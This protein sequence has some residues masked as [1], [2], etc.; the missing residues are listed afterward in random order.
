[1]ADKLLDTG[2]CG[3]PILLMLTVVR[4]WILLSALLVSTGWILSALH[5]LNR[6]GYAVILTSAGIVFIYWQRKTNWRPRKNPAQL[7]HQFRRRF[8]RPAPLLFL[9]LALLALLSGSLYEALNNDADAY[10]LPRVFHWLWSGQWHWIHTFDPRMNIAGCGFEWLSAPLIL[11]TCTDRFLFLINWVSYLMLPGLIF[12]VFK[13]LQVRPRVAW[14][15]MWLLASG[16]C[17]VLQAGSN[18][19]DSFATIYI[20]AAVDLALRAREKNSM[21]DLWLSLLAVALATG[22]KQ[23]NIPLA[24]LWVIAAWPGKRLFWTRRIITTIVVAAFGLLVSIVPVSIFN[25]AHYGT[26]LPVDLARM[27]GGAGFNLNPFWGIIGNSL[28]I[29]VQNLLPPFFPW[30]DSW[31][32]MM[33]RFIHTSFGAH[34]AS[35]EIFGSLRPGIGEVN[36]GIGLGICV[37]TLVSL[38]N[39]NRRPR[40]ANVNGGVANDG[41]VRL[42]RW[43]PFVLLLVFMA[44]DGAFENARQLAPYYPF[45]FPLLLVGAGQARLVRR[46]WWQRLGLLIMGATATLVVIQPNHPLLPAQTLITRLQ[47]EYPHSKLLSM[48]SRIYS[49]QRSLEDQK[50][51]LG[52]ALPPDETIGYVAGINGRYES[53]M[54][55]PFGQRR[56]E[57][58]LP[59]DTPEQL[60]FKGIHYVVIEDIVLQTAN[61]TIEQWLNEYDGNLENK[62]VPDKDPGH[63]VRTLYLVRLRP[64]PGEN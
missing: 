38:L 13:R 56:V 52:D 62:I 21:T 61:E 3:N 9:L 5:Q 17:F 1:V 57:R 14:W 22:A 28:C 16:W 36:A 42:L 48:V 44:R 2:R 49:Y 47:R 64:E 37:L 10:R 46:L 27:P 59:N 15:W 24:L 30:T 40:L 6:T 20:L 11:F 60:R 31:N 51:R 55:L 63:P 50:R 54:W 12:S 19:N 23:T 4:A 53:W 18:F 29:P 34:F 33:D 8:K 41:T 39:G 58:V 45:F 26:W 25:H 32:A 43:M 35:F 7:A